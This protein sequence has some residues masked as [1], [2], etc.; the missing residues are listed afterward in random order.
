MGTKTVTGA[1]IAGTVQGRT[2]DIYEY[3]STQ[4][5]RLFGLIKSNNTS[6][7]PVDPVVKSAFSEAAN[8]LRLDVIERFSQ[9]GLP[10]TDN[11]GNFQFSFKSDLRG[12]SDEEIQ[13]EIERILSDYA[14]GLSLTS[15]AIKS[16]AETGETGYET[17]VRL[18]T[19]L[20]GVNRMLALL[21]DTF[22]YVGVVGG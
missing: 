17:V 20:V 19:S 8:D 4:T 3:T 14:S 16:F 12:K 6:Y 22:Q 21:G 7:S 1:G 2:A 15:E 18:S 11:F 9:L 10:N 5:K 13:E